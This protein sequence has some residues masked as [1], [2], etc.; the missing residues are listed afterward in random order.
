MQRCFVYA[1]PGTG[2]KHRSGAPWSAVMP[3]RSI[4]SGSVGQP[5][6]RTASSWSERPVGVPDWAGSCCLRPCFVCG[7][8][9]ALMAA[10]AASRSALAGASWQMANPAPEVAGALP[11]R[12]AHGARSLRKERWV[13]ERLRPHLDRQGGTATAKRTTGTVGLAEEDHDVIWVRSCRL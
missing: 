7:T 4:I 6:I 9:S 12:P 5:L 11:Q 3:L 8:N 10:F 1:A 13:S 2:W